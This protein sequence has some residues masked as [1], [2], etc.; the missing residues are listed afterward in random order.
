MDVLVDTNILI[1]R[2]SD[3][4]VPEDLRIL[5]R[6]INEEGHRI[7]VHP[8]SVNEIRQDP[9]TERRERAES[10]VETYPELT[11]PPSPSASDTEFRD[12]IPEAPAD[13]NDRVDNMLMFAVYDGAVDYLITQDKGMHRNALELGLE[14]RVFNI[15]DGLEYF[16]EE[17]P[18][19]RAPASI[20]RTTF[21]ELDINDPIFD[22]LKADYPEFVTW[23]ESHPDRPAWV[24]YTGDDLLGALMI[25]K[26]REIESIGESPSLDRETRLK[27]STLKV[28]EERTGSKVGELLISIAIREAINQEIDQLYLT[29]YV[30]DEDYL[31]ELIETWGFEHV[32]SK[33]DGEAVFLKRLTPPFG[34]NPDPLEMA[35][36]YYPSFVDGDRVKKFLVPIWPEYH[37]ML[38][39]SYQE[40]DTPLEEFEGE[41]LSEGNAI[42]KAYLSH[43]NTRKI[44]PGDLLLFYRSRDH[45]QV[46]SLGV[47]EQVFYSLNDPDEISRIVGKRSV[48]SKSEIEEFAESTT[49]VLLFTWHFDLSN[50]VGYSDLLANDVI[51][52]PI[53]TIQQSDEQGYKYIKENGGIDARFARH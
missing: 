4:I 52:G 34:V 1:H 37:N 9:D 31:V 53:Q 45:R 17:P 24:N 23:A 5:E 25:I 35:S 49:T 20:Q 6:E 38:F 42:K 11:Y 50:P 41:F 27:I 36:T 46:T 26:P 29:H 18:S 40:R 12:A 19:I 15:A 7:L 33:T 48:F 28:A 39:T 13:S 51:S 30:S 21:G 47:C 14:D 16:V 44:D 43:A 10:R 3:D 8:A 2:E 32:S 22:S